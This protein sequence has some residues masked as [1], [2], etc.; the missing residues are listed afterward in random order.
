MDN[1]DI[2]QSWEKWKEAF[3]STME[4]CIPKST[5]P[6][7]HNLPWLS[8]SLIQ[9]MKKRNLLYKRAHAT[10]NPTIIAKYRSV[11]NS[12]VNKIKKAKSTYFRRLTTRNSKQFWKIVK[13]VSKK[14]ITIP[15]LTDNNTSETATT[16]AE[17][18]NMLNSFFSR[19]FNYVCPPL[20]TATLPPPLTTEC[21]AN[22]LCSE[23]EVYEYLSK[24]DV[25]KAS[26]PDGMSAKMLKE[27]AQ[28]IT[29]AV[30]KL[31][32]ISITVRELPS[33]WKHALITPI[34]KS[35]E[36]S[37]VSNYRPISILSILSKVLERHIHYQVLQHLHTNR[38]LALSQYGFLKG[39]STTG[40]LVS[41]IDEW[42]KILD[43]GF[44][45]CAIFFDLRKAFDSVP[46]SILLEKLAEMNLDLHLLRWIANYLCL[47]TQAV[48]VKGVTSN[49]Q[50]VVS[51]VPQ[52]SVLG[53]LLFLIYIDGIC[54]VKVSDGT[55]ILFADDLLLYRPIKS[56]KDFELLQH[57]VS[58]IAN[59]VSNN[60]LCFNTQKCKQMLVSRK[61]FPSTAATP[62]S[63]DGKELELVSEYKYLGVWITNDLSWSKQIEEMCK[64]GNKQIGFIY[65]RF[66][67]HC[68]AD[69]LKHLYT[70][71]VR[72]HLEYAV[73]VW[74]PHLV[75]HKDAIER[76]Q[77][78]ALKVCNKDWNSSYSDLLTQAN[79]P[80]L[81][82]RRL[83]LKL[84]FLYQLV[85]NLSHGNHELS[86]RA[87]PVN[88]RNN[89]P[90][91]LSRPSCRTCHYDSSF[92]PHTVSVW[93]TLP[94]SILS[95]MS[96]SSFK[97]AVNKHLC[98]VHA[99]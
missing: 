4:S 25:S 45:V 65:R 55:L 15:T 81:A 31:F 30:T 36:S 94:M 2:H 99:L 33:D 86:F 48:G 58:A 49:S 66:Y 1:S 18:A 39:R 26:G 21:P 91:L 71:L 5:L 38:P 70:T 84:S 89:N 14:E 88:V 68:S 11:R 9:S 8:K 42:Q 46:H 64:K 3:L 82:Q 93:N 61:R 44:D 13:R 27:T 24:L 22:I 52:G 56:A 43:S 79:L 92:F 87:M 57:D 97:R 78:F 69:T 6:K 62:I 63:I 37:I 29:P 85:N 96:L 75:K 98:D 73:P 83:E 28:S 17:K 35:N 54:G 32:N 67:Q 12:L 19:C 50:A 80:P 10:N 7:R 20:T 76:V 77:K 53:P 74:D 41:A 72:P 23:E 51:G 34:P 59:W 90:Y 40:A 47:R 16:S 60:F 95:S